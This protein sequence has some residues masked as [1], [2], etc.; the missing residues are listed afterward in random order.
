MSITTGIVPSSGRPMNSSKNFRFLGVHRRWRLEKFAVVAIWCSRVWWEDPYL[1]RKPNEARWRRG[2]AVVE[3]GQTESSF[4][5]E[6]NWAQITGFSSCSW[7]IWFE[8]RLRR[9][10]VH[11]TV[12]LD[13]WST[14]SSAFTSLINYSHLATCGWFQWSETFFHWVLEQSP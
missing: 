7:N 4:V 9:S 6:T 13:S 1:P 12:F 8:P 5:I 3:H 11:V 2:V 14:I 10:V